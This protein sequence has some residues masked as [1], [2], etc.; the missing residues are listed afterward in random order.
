MRD[1]NI[2]YK[3]GSVERKYQ[4][5]FIVESA[6]GK[7]ICETKKASEMNDTEV[8]AKATAAA[9]WCRHATEATG[10]SWGYLLIPHDHVRMSMTFAGFVAGCRV[11]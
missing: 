11:N 5:D 8:L 10:E 4:P 1:I 3:S 9:L 6:A 7:W 2:Y